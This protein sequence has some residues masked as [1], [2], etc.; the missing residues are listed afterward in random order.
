M[1]LNV[2]CGHKPSGHVNVDLY[3][4]A[5]I[6]RSENRFPHDRP[7]I[8]KR[9]KNLVRA[10]AEHLPFRANMFETVYSRSTIEHVSNPI[11]MIKE[12]IRVSNF[13]V[14]IICP[15]R[16]SQY[17]KSKPH[18]SFFSLKWF[19]AVTEKLGYYCQVETNQWRYIPHVIFP[20]FQLP[21]ECKVTIFKG[22]N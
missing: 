1:I 14:I 5:T 22:R 16:Y 20:L 2:G 17:A 15:H 3:V 12:M 9:I 18:E 10:D 11:T 4:K 8:K 21:R 6:H 7:L 13:E 19:L